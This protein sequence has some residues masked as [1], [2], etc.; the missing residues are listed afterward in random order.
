MSSTMTRRWKR[1]LRSRKRPT[2]YFDRSEMPS[3]AG[4]TIGLS[5]LISNDSRMKISS[6]SSS[7]LMRWNASWLWWSNC[8]NWTKHKSRS[9]AVMRQATNLKL[10]RAMEWRER[11]LLRS[12]PTTKSYPFTSKSNCSRQLSQWKCSKQMMNWCRMRRNYHGACKKHPASQISIGGSLK[13]TKST[14]SS[15]W[16]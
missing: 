2:I 5:Q 6:S 1:S 12:Y 7:Q 13:H 11:S 15:W 16:M 10:Q 3:M 8:E 4:F 14:R 9:T